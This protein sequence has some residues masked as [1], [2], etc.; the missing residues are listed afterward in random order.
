MKC[1]NPLCPTE[2]LYLRSGTLH[3]IDCVGDGDRILKRQI[4]WLCD[5]CEQ[6]FAV[7]PW[8][9]PGEQLQPR[10]KPALPYSVTKER[11]SLRRKMSVG[12]R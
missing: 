10:A 4:I 3:S 8:R 6:L 9:S 12:G 5:S 2:A 7:E 1:A 11:Y